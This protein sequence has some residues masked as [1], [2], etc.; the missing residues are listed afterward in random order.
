MS[1]VKAIIYIFYI[2]NNNQDTEIVKFDKHFVPKQN[3]IHERGQFNQTVQRAGDAVGEFVRHLY[4]IAEHCDF[5]K[6]KEYIRDRIVLG[7]TD[8]ELS[9]RLQLRS[10]VTLED[11]IHAARQS[12]IVKIQMS[13]QASQG[14]SQNLQEVRANTSQGA[15]Q[16]APHKTRKQGG[17]GGR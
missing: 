9:E 8:R 11:A 17:G 12:D 13:A 1:D 4:E 3:V 10:D 15:A 2:L 5:N 7:M 14:T 6:K 16:G